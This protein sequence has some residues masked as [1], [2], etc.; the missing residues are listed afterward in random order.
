MK[1]KGHGF[2]VGDLVEEKG[3]YG[4]VIRTNSSEIIVYWQDVE[5]GWD[6]DPMTVRFVAHIPGLKN[7][8][9]MTESYLAKNT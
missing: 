7:L 6:T 3:H 1:A 5:C 9:R 2:K 8:D 4:I